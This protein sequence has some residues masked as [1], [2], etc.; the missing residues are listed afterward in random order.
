MKKTNIINYN[1][2]YHHTIRRNIKQYVIYSVKCI[3]DDGDH[4]MKTCNTHDWTY[5]SKI[6]SS[7]TRKGQV[8]VPVWAG[9]K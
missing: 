6:C 1:P 7:P 4:V 2:Q 8:Q 5:K 9:E 3:Y